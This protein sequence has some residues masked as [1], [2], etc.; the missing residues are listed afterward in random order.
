MAFVKDDLLDKDSGK[1]DILSHRNG[2]QESGFQIQNIKIQIDYKKI[3][4]FLVAY[5]VMNSL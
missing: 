1:W 4:M 3:L 2:V 5:W